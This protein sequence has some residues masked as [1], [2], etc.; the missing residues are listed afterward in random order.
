V[1]RGVLAQLARR[2]GLA[3]ATLVKENDPVLCWVEINS[4]GRGGV[5]TGPA[6]EVDHWLS[7]FPPILFIV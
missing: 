3:S 6:V 4:I 1:L 2:L 5:A 7:I